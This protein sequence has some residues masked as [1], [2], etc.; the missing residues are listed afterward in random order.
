MNQIFYNQRL[1][2]GIRPFNEIDISCTVV[3]LP[4]QLSAFEKFG[5][6]LNPSGCTKSILNKISG[7]IILTQNF[8]CAR[9]VQRDESN[10]F[11]GNKKTH[12]KLVILIE[13]DNSQTV[14]YFKSTHVFTSE[15]SFRITFVLSC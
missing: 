3:C 4:L 1:A 6:F 14:L 13:S 8:L 9:A 5:N 10:V 12:S 2:E 15:Y 11:K 7:L